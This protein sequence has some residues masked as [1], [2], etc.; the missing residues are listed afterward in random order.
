MVITGSAD[1]SLKVWDISR[2]TYRQ[3]V[4]LRHSS[5]STCVDVASDGQNV[6]SGHMDGGIRFWDL[7]SGERTVDASGTFVCFDRPYLLFCF[8]EVII[9][10]FRN[11]VARRRYFVCSIQPRK[12]HASVDE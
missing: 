4:M 5:T 7:R 12:Q 6:V 3:G 8:T 10:L 11:R 9:C 2:K 1:R